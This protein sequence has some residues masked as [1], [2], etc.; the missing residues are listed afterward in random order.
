VDYTHLS[1]KLGAVYSLS[2]N[3]SLYASYNHGFRAP[4]ESQLFR[5]GSGALADALSKAQLALALKPI[6]A[7]QFELGW[8]GAADGWSY[9][10][11]LYQLVKQD[12]LVSQRDL[13]TNIS[14]S[15][16]AGKTEHQGIELALGKAFNSQWRLAT[17]LSYASHRY[18]DWVTATADY[19]GKEMETAP[20]LMANTRLSWTPRDGTRAELEWVRLGDYWL[21]ASNA[22]AFGKYPGHDV[23]NLRVSQSLSKGVNVFARLMNLTDQR[24]ADSASVSS[25]TAVFSPALPRALYVGLDATW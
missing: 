12:D 16:N 10:L 8:R 5:A 20:R 3:I 4:S 17:A 23:F 1:P 11:T 15:V 22:A 24:Y 21:E 9:D 19:S 25:S 2:P 6:K 13:A 18:V 7:N 14:T